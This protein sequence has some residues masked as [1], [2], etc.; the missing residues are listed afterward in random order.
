MHQKSH[1]VAT[2]HWHLP[3]LPAGGFAITPFMFPNCNP[4]CK[5]GCMVAE[6]GEAWL[7]AQPPCW[8]SWMCSE[9]RRFGPAVYSRTQKKCLVAS[10]SWSRTRNML[11]FGVLF[12]GGSKMGDINGYVH[13]NKLPKHFV[14]FGTVCWLPCIGFADLSVNHRVKPVLGQH[15]VLNEDTLPM[16]R[17]GLLEVGMGRRWD[18]PIHHHPGPLG[19]G[20]MMWFLRF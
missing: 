11:L 3:L 17:D 5:R 15:L 16:V 4:C 1:K 13:I 7:G 19:I 18:K 6:Y 9:G 8:T 20:R 14:A 10:F 2:G 12:L